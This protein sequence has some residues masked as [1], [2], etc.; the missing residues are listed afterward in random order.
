MFYF[1]VLQTAAF[2]NLDEGNF[3]R[4]SIT[5]SASPVNF[6]TQRA[7]GKSNTYHHELTG[8]NLCEYGRLAFLSREHSPGACFYAVLELRMDFY[9]F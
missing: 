4:C 1:V 2:S 9:I 6:K 5:P 3:S 8:K 7:N